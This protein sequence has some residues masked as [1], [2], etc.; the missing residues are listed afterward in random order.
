MLAGTRVPINGGLNMKNITVTLDEAMAIWLREHAAK[1]GVSVSRYLGDMVHE[2][3]RERHEYDEA[4]RRFL[5]Q[6]PFHFGWA[7]GRRP[8]RQELHDRARARTDMAHDSS[9][10]KET[11]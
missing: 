7:D 1:N 2:R 3:M 10:P 9:S 8:T 6:K 11:K 4:M 5:S